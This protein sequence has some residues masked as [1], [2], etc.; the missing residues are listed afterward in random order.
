MNQPTKQLIDRAGLTLKPRQM[1]DDLGDYWVSDQDHFDDNLEAVRTFFDQGA[2]KLVQ[3][4]VIE[5]GQTLVDNTPAVQL[6]ENSY[7]QGY[8]RAMNDCIH[9]IYAHFGLEL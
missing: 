6:H 4:V 8:D 1:Y 5:C 2:E 3:L 9:H 7:N